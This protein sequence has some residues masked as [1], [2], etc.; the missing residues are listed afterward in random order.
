[1]AIT[2]RFQTLLP[3]SHILVWSKQH[4]PVI[5]Q[6]PAACASHCSGCQLVKSTQH[7]QNDDF[8]S[9]TFVIP[10]IDL[11]ISVSLPKVQFREQ[12][13]LLIGVYK[14]DWGRD[15]AVFYVFRI[16]NFVFSHQGLT[17]NKVVTGIIMKQRS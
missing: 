15:I 8:P 4:F 13:M 16:S 7:I 10:C 11:V 14:K 12:S 6:M 17:V 5:N 2:Y 3:V 9:H 1:M